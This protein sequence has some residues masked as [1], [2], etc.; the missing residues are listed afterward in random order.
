MGRGM[1]AS[2]D[3]IAALCGNPSAAGLILDFDGVLAPIVADP[4]SS[5]M[6]DGLPE[7]LERVARRLRLTAII[8]GRPLEFLIERAAVPGVALLGS[9]GVESLLGTVRSRHV[10]VI[11]WL[12]SI[13]LATAELEAAVSD[14][15]GV[16]VE[17]KSGLSVAVHWRQ[18]TD[19]AAAEARVIE[20][21]SRL[22]EDTGLR[23]DSGKLVEEL[24]PPLS[25][26]KGTAVASLVKENDLVVVAYAGDDLGDLPAFNAAVA[27]GG[28]A[29]L[30][31]HGAETSHSLHELATATF[32]GVEGFGQWLKRLDVELG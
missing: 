14:L 32:D 6:L 17:E 24:R 29:L 26:D 13:R 18:A 10:G 11:P 20:I 9:Y 22:A 12:E 2:D 1:V 15:P 8:S 28:H 31:D 19:R 3:T 27:V 30:V 4:T 23:R 16:R 21:V 7:V 25:V 5:R